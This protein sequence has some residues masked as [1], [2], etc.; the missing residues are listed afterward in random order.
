[1][2]AVP[3]AGARIG[4]LPAAAAADQ[5][6]SQSAGATMILKRGYAVVSANAAIWQQPSVRPIDT[7]EQ[8]GLPVLACPCTTAILC[9]LGFIKQICSIILRISKICFCHNRAHGSPA[10]GVDV[11]IVNRQRNK[12]MAAL[13][14]SHAILLA[15]ADRGKPAV[16]STT[17]PAAVMVY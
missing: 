8:F 14:V 6:I 1:M 7:F 2:L 15:Y 12:A 9:I 4:S 16:A 10:A 13:R 11:A 5:C 3:P 17:A